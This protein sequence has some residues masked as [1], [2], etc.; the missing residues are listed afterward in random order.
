MKNQTQLTNE[1]AGGTMSL[2]SIPFSN[3]KYVAKY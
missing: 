1:D 3:E 2:M